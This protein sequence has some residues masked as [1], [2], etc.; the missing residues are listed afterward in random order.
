MG[1][2]SVSANS[3][4][5]LIKN[6][7]TYYVL[8]NDLVVSKDRIQEIVK[9]SLFHVPSP[10]N[11][12]STRV[13]VLFDEHHHKLWDIAIDVLKPVIPENLWD[14]VLEKLNGF[15]AATATVSSLLAPLIPLLSYD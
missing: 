6:R 9:E 13:V 10:Y 5:D 4:L 1:S 11:C 12:Q 8:N 2:S 7:R 14:F 3:V 15:R